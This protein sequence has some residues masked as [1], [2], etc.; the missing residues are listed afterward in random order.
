MSEITAL[1]QRLQPVQPLE[2]PTA[3]PSSHG[4]GE[5]RAVLQS[6]L[7]SVENSQRT[8]SEAVD[9]FLN[10]KGGELHS[11]ILATQRAELQLH[12]FLQVRNKVLSAYQEIIRAQV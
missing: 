11:T 5:F 7:H 4:G 8:A 3:A 12:L 10:G 1:M 6:A 9:A 2:R